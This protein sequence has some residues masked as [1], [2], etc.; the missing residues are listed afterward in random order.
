MVLCVCD[1][2]ISNHVSIQTTATVYCPC[3][4]F[5]LQPKILCQ[6]FDAFVGSIIEYGCEI[7]GFTKS[8]ELERIHLKFLKYI[9]CVKSSTSNM[10][11]Y[12]EL[13]RYPLYISRYVRII[14]YWTKVVQTENIII[15][16]LYDVMMQQMKKGEVN[17]ASKVKYLLDTHV[18]LMYGMH[19]TV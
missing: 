8:K 3:I 17:W 13:G 4:K 16:S 6:L 12:G 19:K 14:K 9:L 11:V 1:H 18:F 2:T 10:A 15:K 7:W 5:K